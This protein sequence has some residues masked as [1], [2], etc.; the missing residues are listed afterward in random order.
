MTKT[1]SPI[2]KERNLIIMLPPGMDI[3]EKVGTH[4]RYIK[5]PMAY[6]LNVFPVLGYQL[7]D[8]ARN[9][10][11]PSKG[12]SVGKAA[13]N[14]FSAVAGS[15]NPA[16]GSFDPRDK[17]QL[18]IAVSPTIVDAGIQMGA[19]VDS[20]GKPTGP[21]KS[22]Y[23]KRPDSENVSAQ[24]HGNVNHRIARWI[25]D[26]TGGNAARSGAIDIE[27]GTLKNMQGIVGGGLGKFVGDVV[28]LG[29]L[30]VM[31]APIQP[32]DI[33]IYKAFY[34]EYDAKSGMS[35]FY[36]RSKKALEEFDDMKSEQKLGIKRDYS[37]DEKFLQSMGAYAKNI[38]EFTGKLKQQEVHVSESNSTPK[39][40]D[41]KR[42]MI[43]RQREKMAEDF[44]AK[45][46]EKES[47]LK[48]AGS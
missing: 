21:Q 15:Y 20:F 11:D 1:A 43:Q 7:A 8:L 13:I 24:N 9:A 22:P 3:G 17:V 35:L 10:S 41:M 14:M 48:K 29:Y 33:P 4:G 40:K 31:D 2:E 12:I 18:A 16:G 36:E 6:G 30:G 32:R 5:I 25:N 38:S 26:V 19:G 44:N 46:Y 37:D 39:E 47:N 28:N 23:D 42:R 27:P 34:G 45:W